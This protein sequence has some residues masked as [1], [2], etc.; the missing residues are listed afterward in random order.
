MNREEWLT[1]AIIKIEMA[2]F[3]PLQMKMPT[4]WK[5]TCGWSKGASAKAIGVCVDPVCAKD[6]TTHIFV[7]PTQDNAMNIL[8]TL[9][10][11]MIHAI[12]GVDAGHKAPFREVVKKLEMSKP[13]TSSHP[14]PETA[15]W[16]ALEEILAGL[17]PYPHAAMVP[18]KKPSKPQPWA[19]W[20]SAKEPK[21][22]VLANT[23]KVA[24]YGLPRDPWGFEMVPVDPGKIFGL[25]LDP[26]QKNLFE[27]P[28]EPDDDSNTDD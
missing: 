15:L 8:G 24:Q 22:T 26:R 5:A 2:V 10:H 1:K 14:V 6:G 7:I 17:G 12:I 19:R 18:R 9:T 11:E 25:K 27:L 28:G 4:K 23:K 13:M 21:F 3:W 16:K 20:K